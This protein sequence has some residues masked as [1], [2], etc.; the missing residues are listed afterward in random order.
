M[1]GLERVPK[2]HSFLKVLITFSS[3]CFAWIFFRANTVSDALDI[4]SNVVMGWEKAFAVETLENIP[5][6]GPLKFEL[7]VSF[8]SIGILLSVHLMEQRGNIIDRFSEKPAWI[9]WP[10]YYSLLLAILLFG[11]FGARQFIYF[12][13]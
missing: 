9:R 8:I 1:I 10:V 4:I 5:F 3:V 13:F 11:N 12:Q 2:L 6:W 7:V